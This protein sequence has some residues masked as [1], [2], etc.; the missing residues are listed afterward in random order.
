MAITNLFNDRVHVVS[1]VAFGQ[2]MECDL[3]YR[4]ELVHIL[5]SRLKGRFKFIIL[6]L[7]YS[8]RYGYRKNPFEVEAYRLEVKNADEI[9]KEFGL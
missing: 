2:L 9:K 4:H 6:Y 3:L 5:Q 7:F 8:I 1:K